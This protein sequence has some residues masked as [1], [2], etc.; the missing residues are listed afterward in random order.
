MGKQAPQRRGN[1]VWLSVYG[2]G[3]VVPQKSSV[4]LETTF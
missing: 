4:C 2:H 3:F 1:P